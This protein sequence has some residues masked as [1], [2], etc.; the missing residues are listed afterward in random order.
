MFY[1]KKRWGNQN[2]IKFIK[3]YWDLI[4]GFVAGVS[5]AVLSRFKIDKITLIN[6]ILISILLSVGVLKIIKETIEKTK[7]RD[8]VI[9]KML[10]NQTPMKAIKLASDPTEDG[11]EVGKNVIILLGVFKQFMEKLKTLFDKFKGYMLAICMMILSIVELCGGYIN[12]LCG[13]VFTVHGVEVLPII[14][15][16]AS[17]VIGLI[18]NGY[19]KDQKEKIKALMS[20]TSSGDKNQIVANEITKTLKTKESELKDLNKKLATQEKELEVITKKFDEMKNTYDAKVQMNGMTPQLATSDEVKSS[21]EN[22]KQ[23]KLNV[24]AQNV[25]INKT[26]AVIDTTKKIGRAHV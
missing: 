7:R 21:Y 6:S 24:D 9:D 2:V 1:N 13:G 26:K 15:L 25:E 17:T 8:T 3:K 16:V 5:L 23:A 10:D 22:M 14:T 11:E 20:K 18:S 4:I 19:T 12:D